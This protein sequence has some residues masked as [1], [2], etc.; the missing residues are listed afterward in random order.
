MLGKVDRRRIKLR[1]MEIHADEATA[2]RN[3]AQPGGWATGF[4][5]RLDRLTEIPG[6]N[7]GVHVTT[8]RRCRHPEFT[9]KFH[10]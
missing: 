8:D 10:S 1:G 3:R 6:G 2:T 9:G 5:G 7:D 4:L